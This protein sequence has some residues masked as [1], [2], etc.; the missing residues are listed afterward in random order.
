MV[1]GLFRFSLLLFLISAVGLIGLNR[2][3]D[4][5]D[6]HRIQA[7][8][9]IIE[10]SGTGPGN[11]LGFAVNSTCDA[12]RMAPNDV[13]TSAVGIE[14]TGEGAYRLS[15]PELEVTGD[16]LTCGGG[17]WFSVAI[18]N[19]SYTPDSHIVAIGDTESFDVVATFGDAPNECQA[20]S[21][22]II[23]TLRAEA[24]EAH[25]PTPTA[26]STPQDNTGGETPSTSTPVP[27]STLTSQTAGTQATP[28]ATA[29]ARAT[30]V[31]TFT[32]EVLPSRFP[33]TG[34]GFDSNNPDGFLRTVFL[35][36][37]LI[38]AGFFILALRIRSTERQ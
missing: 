27:T 20:M 11:T 5:R 25:T 30:P 6:V 33:S 4:P 36:M 32:S 34:Q 10:L 31:A 22:E 29:T 38:G 3:L 23:I 13:C 17:G 18:A 26:T 21:A 16:L 35:G 7:H 37:A 19:I 12:S 24:T 1:K 9:I 14:N 15:Q 2:G 28:P 8:A